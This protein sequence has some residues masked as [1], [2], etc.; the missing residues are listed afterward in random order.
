MAA[1]T[2]PM[3]MRTPSWV[4]PG[5]LARSSARKPTAVVRA[6]KIMARRRPP[7]RL[8]HGFRPLL[9]LVARLL[10]AAINKDGEIDAQPDE[11]GA[12]ADR[13][14]VQFAEDENTGGESDQAAEKQRD[15]HAKEGEPAV[16]TGV[17][18]AA[19]QDNRAEQGQDD[20]LPHAQ[21]NFRH[22]SGPAGHEHLEGT[23]FP[24]FLRGGLERLDL[25]HEAL[26]FPGAAVGLVRDHEKNAHGAIVRDERLVGGHARVHRERLERGPDQSQRIEL[27]FKLRAR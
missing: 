6:P 3:A 27:E 26:A 7:G 4:N 5:E 11:D 24:A 20:V 1:K 17:E 23:A 8:A 16:K 18:N 19:D 13:D 15:A 2:M 10:V 22:V 25:G 9:A 14:H 12:E 21:R